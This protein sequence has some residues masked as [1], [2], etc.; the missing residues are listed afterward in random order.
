MAQ[1][2]TKVEAR[3]IATDAYMRARWSGKLRWRADALL[4]LSDKTIYRQRGARQAGL[5]VKTEMSAR[6]P[7]DLPVLVSDSSKARQ[8]LDRTIHLCLTA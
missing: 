6:R 2:I 8:L 4:P 7:G 1:G 5:P 3:T